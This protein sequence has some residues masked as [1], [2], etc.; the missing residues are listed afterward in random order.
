MQPAMRLYVI[1][2]QRKNRMSL[3]EKAFPVKGI[4]QKTSQLQ[5][6]PND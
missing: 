5:E 6:K 3:N 2:V 4:L 1:D